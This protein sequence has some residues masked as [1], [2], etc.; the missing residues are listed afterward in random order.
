MEHTNFLSMHDIN[1]CGKNINTMRKSTETLLDASRVCL[2][3]STWKSMY[4]FMSHHQ[5][6]EENHNIK[7]ANTAFINVSKFKH[8]GMTAKNATFLENL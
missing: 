7:L 5:N 4:M 3:I 1:L 8:L 2:E 6:V